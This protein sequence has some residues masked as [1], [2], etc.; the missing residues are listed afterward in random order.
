MAFWNNWIWLKAE[1][2]CIAVGE[3]T[4]TTPWNGQTTTLGPYQL[5]VITGQP[6][7]MQIP[8]AV[9]EAVGCSTSACVNA[10]LTPSSETIQPLN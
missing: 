3:T 5:G 1:S 7:T 9:V 8:V 2:K 4:H 6:D 10:G